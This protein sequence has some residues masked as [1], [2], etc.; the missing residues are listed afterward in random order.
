MLRLLIIH[1][2]I[3]EWN[4]KNPKKVQFIENESKINFQFAYLS[5]IVIK[6]ICSNISLN[7]CFSS[8]KLGLDKISK[9]DKTFMIT[10]T[11][12]FPN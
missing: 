4:Q 10:V 7:N 2:S 6:L 5:E 9:L 1:Y 8:R 12:C 11:S 3:F